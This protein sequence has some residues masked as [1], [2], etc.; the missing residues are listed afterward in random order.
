[1][2]DQPNRCQTWLSTLLK[3]ENLTKNRHVKIVKISSPLKQLGQLNMIDV[4]NY[5]PLKGP[6]E[7]LSIYMAYNR[8]C[9]KSYNA[10]FIINE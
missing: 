4:H 8:S 3:I 10:W 9:L 6:S 5:A 7:L 2:V 1:M